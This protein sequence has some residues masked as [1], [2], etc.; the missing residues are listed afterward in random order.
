MT[1]AVKLLDD[2]AVATLLGVGETKLREL[3][4]D[5]PDKAARPWVDLGEKRPMR[6]WYPALP[7][8]WAW[9]QEVEE[10]RGS[11]RRSGDTASAGDR[12]GGD[13][14]VTHLTSEPRSG[15]RSKSKKRSPSKGGGR[16]LS[17]AQRAQGSQTPETG[18]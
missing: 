18:S 11:R 10:W 17:L 12:M 4:H 9:L 2:E 5:T 8:L 14:N 1:V 7:Q 15:S 3:I 13:S 6:R 16:R